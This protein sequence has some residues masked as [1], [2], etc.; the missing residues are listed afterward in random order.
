MYKHIKSKVC[1]SW[2][3]LAFKSWSP[4]TQTYKHTRD[5]TEHITMRSPLNLTSIYHKKN[6]IRFVDR[7]FVATGQ[8][9]CTFSCQSDLSKQ[10]ETVQVVP[11]AI[12][13]LDVALQ[14]ILS[15]HSILHAAC[16]AIN[17]I[18]TIYPSKLN[19][20]TGRPISLLS[21]FTVLLACSWWNK[22]SIS[23]FIT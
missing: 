10:S 13:E 16:R 3:N 23:A 11:S 18:S 21:T 14:S 17:L 4:N 20:R 19:P 2:H 7:T 5:A 1:R 15:I 8:H 12:A 9:Q 6:Y 22:S